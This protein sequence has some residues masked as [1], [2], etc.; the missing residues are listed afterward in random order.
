VALDLQLIGSPDQHIDIRVRP[1][2][3]SEVKVDRPSTRDPPW[4]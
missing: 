3:S 2:L 4:A 1:G